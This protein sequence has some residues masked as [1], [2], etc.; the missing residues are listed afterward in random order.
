MAEVI[1]KLESIKKLTIHHYYPQQLSHAR[2]LPKPRWAI[3]TSATR[4]YASSALQTTNIPIPDVFVTADDVTSG[5]PK[6]VTARHYSTPT[7]HHCT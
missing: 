2:Y 7:I 1:A 6:C 5:K 3:C 4:A